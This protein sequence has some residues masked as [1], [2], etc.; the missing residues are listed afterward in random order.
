MKIQYK[1]TDGGRTKEGFGTE[2]RDC[3]VRALACAAKISY[4]DAH[5]LAIY[6]GRKNRRRFNA[7]QLYDDLGYQQ[8]FTC[9]YRDKKPITVKTAIEKYPKG[10]YI[11]RISRH[12]FAVINGRIHDKTPIGLKARVLNIWIIK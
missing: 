8:V 5:D 3:G 7:D 1:K 9:N 12:V 10:R 11:L 2:V 4:S 6:S